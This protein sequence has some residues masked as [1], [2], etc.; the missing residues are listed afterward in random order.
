[1]KKKLKIFQFLQNFFKNLVILIFF[2]I[3]INKP[4]LSSPSQI[5]SVSLPKNIK[6]FID[7]KDIKKYYFYLGRIVS[8]T[9]IITKKEKKTLNQKS[10]KKNN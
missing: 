2:T 4:A 6:I 7:K 10:K 3:F 9:K 5:Y 8:K 1:M